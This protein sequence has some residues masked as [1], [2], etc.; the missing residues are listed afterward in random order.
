MP[1]ENKYQKQVLK[2][3]MVVTSVLEF[4]FAHARKKESVI[5]Y[6]TLT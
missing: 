6:V 2:L 4:P 1:I 3:Q 5:H